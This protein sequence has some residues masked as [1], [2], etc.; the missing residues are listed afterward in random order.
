MASRILRTRKVAQKVSQ[1]VGFTGLALGTCTALAIPV[2]ALTFNGSYIPNSRSAIPVSNSDLINGLSPTST[3]YTPT[4]EGGPISNFTNGTAGSVPDAASNPTNAIFSVGA[5]WSATYILP[6]IFNLASIAVTAGHQDNRVN[7]FYDIF[8]STNGT[9]FTSLSNGGGFAYTPS[10]G[11][12]GSTQTILTDSSGII[13]SNIQAVRFQ[14]NNNGSTVFRELDVIGTAA[15]V[16][17]EFNSTLGLVIVGGYWGI[18]K[19]R[20]RYQNLDL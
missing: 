12:G 9:T 15:P 4:F 18:S 8:V 20:K 17:F 19:L 2:Q 3:N 14:A 5:S 10:N 7:Q 1:T 6:G 13:A 11:V 16:P